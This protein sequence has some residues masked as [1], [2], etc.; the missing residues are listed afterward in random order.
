MKNKRKPVEMTA[1]ISEYLLGTRL[2]ISK[3]FKLGD[4]Y[5]YI[6][7]RYFQYTGIQKYLYILYSKI[8]IYVCISFTIYRESIYRYLQDR[9]KGNPKL[10]ILLLKDSSFLIAYAMDFRFIFFKIA[11]KDNRGD[12][13]YLA[14]I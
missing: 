9:K 1:G 4:M 12:I 3:D 6:F 8:N 14:V 13:K 7:L 11:R 2:N 10:D 5:L